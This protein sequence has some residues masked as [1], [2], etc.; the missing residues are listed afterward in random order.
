MLPAGA[1]YGA[2]CTRIKSGGFRHTTL[3]VRLE[4][5]LFVLPVLCKNKCAK[6]AIAVLA[7][8]EGAEKKRRQAKK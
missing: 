1:L 2:K 4:F 6:L 8:S 7:A 3:S 5:S